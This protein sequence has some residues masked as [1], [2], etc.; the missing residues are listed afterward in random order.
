MQLAGFANVKK[1]LYFGFLKSSNFMKLWLVI[2]DIESVKATS[3]QVDAPTLQSFIS[4]SK[5][6]YFCPYLVVQ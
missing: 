3:D 1:N 4:D 2:L 6:G 5:Q